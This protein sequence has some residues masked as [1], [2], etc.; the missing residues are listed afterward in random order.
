VSVIG[1]GV[2]EHSDLKAKSEMANLT[3]EVLE[4]AKKLK[5]ME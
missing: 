4:K 2:Y 3:K 5:L 1:Q